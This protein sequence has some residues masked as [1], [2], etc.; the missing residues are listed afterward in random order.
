MP[1]LAPVW[2]FSPSM[3]GVNYIETWPQEWSEGC[4]FY[5]KGTFSGTVYLCTLS[6]K[7]VGVHVI[8]EPP[9]IILQLL[10]RRVDEDEAEMVVIEKSIEPESLILEVPGLSSTT[11]GPCGHSVE[12]AIVDQGLPPSVLP[13]E[14]LGLDVETAIKID[15]RLILKRRQGWSPIPIRKWRGK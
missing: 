14:Y 4:K 13:T 10:N 1:S 9:P 5:H 7:H 15:K 6:N 8:S 2:V 11:W 12:P 3:I